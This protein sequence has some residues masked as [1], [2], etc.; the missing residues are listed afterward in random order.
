[1]L[2][3]LAIVLLAALAGGGTARGADAPAQSPHLRCLL[4]EPGAC[5]EY[6]R[7]IRTTCGTCEARAAC[8][9]ER[10]ARLRQAHAC[11]EAQS[12]C[13]V[14]WGRVGE[15]SNRACDGEAWPAAAVSASLSARERCLLEQPDGCE[16]YGRELEQRC[17]ERCLHHVYCIRRRAMIIRDFEATSPDL[18][19]RSSIAR[20]AVEYC[21]RL[22]L[23]EAPRQS[24]KP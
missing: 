12:K 10:A 18:A 8:W 19:N 3:R 14:R 21:D 11:K 17:G 6:A 15:K 23:P 7:E 13:M 22:A 16:A 5:E 9:E 4:D 2:G 20:W 1:M 24:P